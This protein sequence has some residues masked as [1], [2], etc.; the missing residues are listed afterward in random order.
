[1]GTERKSG[2]GG[3][4][5][6]AMGYLSLRCRNMD[7]RC[8]DKGVALTSV[9]RMRGDTRRGTR[10]ELGTAFHDEDRCNLAGVG[11]GC[12]AIEYTS[13]L[14]VHNPDDETYRAS[15]HLTNGGHPILQEHY[16][17]LST[18][19]GARQNRIT[20]P[21]TISNAPRLNTMPERC[22]SS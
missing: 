14:I 5:S 7:D 11:V 19:E 15:S 2:R 20:N 3:W 4:V 18:A 10:D 21:T 6:T 12:A 1:M 16:R 9:S 17:P 13:V 8:P 22:Y